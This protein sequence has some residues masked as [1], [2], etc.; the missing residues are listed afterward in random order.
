[1][2]LSC[3]CPILHFQIRQ[4]AEF[5]GVVRE[6]G[7]VQGEGVCGNEQ[8]ERADGFPVFFQCGTDAALVVHVIHRIIA[9][10]R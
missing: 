6:Q 10:R 3:S 4:A 1:M 5:A 9:G 8:I 7:G 2:P